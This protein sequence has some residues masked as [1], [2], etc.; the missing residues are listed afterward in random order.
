M[1]E[2]ILKSKKVAEL[3][4]VAKAF[5]V[6]GSS[7]MKKEELIAAMLSMADEKIS[8]KTATKKE[9]DRNTKVETVDAENKKTEAV[10]AENKKAEAVEAENKKAET[11]KHKRQVQEPSNRTKTEK[12]RK[13]AEQ[14][15]TESS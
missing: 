7:A 11:E 14:M 9:K 4:E 3:R 1:D 8:G 10:E 5:G 6:H 15:K 12:L 13:T 2:K